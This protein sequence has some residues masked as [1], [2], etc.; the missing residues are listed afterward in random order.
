MKRTGNSLSEQVKDKVESGKTR[1]KKPELD[2][3][4]TK[5]ISTGSTL[6]DLAISGGRVRGGGIPAGV[7]VEIFG[8]PQSGKSILL[9]EIAGYVQRQKGKVKFHDPEGRLVKEFA[10]VFDLDVDSIELTMPDTVTELFE[11]VR[12]WEPETHDVVNGIFADSLAALTTKAELEG[13]DPYG[14]RRAKEFSEQLRLTCRE[15]P[16]KNYL[17]ICS[18]QIRENIDAGLYGPKFKSPGGKGL[19]HYSSVRLRTKVLKR[20][21]PK[22]K[23]YVE[24]TRETGIEV[25]VEVVK[26][27]VWKPSRKAL[28]TIDLDYGIDDVSENL[29]FLK[30]HRGDNTYKLHGETLARNRM[31]AVRIIEDTDAESELREEVIDLWEEIEEKFKTNRKTK[32]RDG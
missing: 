17:M 16:R 5:M 20:I 6:L 11:V 28:L 26:N 19:E 12:N 14:M 3:D 10:E 7:F 8:P 29:R 23:V 24:E 27:S 15:F 32:K 13:S 4:I 21:K 1:A 18:N 9:C 30:D 2:G 22:R 31:A 25:E